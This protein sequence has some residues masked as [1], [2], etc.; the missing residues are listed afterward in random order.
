MFGGNHELQLARSG[1]MVEAIDPIDTGDVIC[2]TDAT[3]DNVLVSAVIIGVQNLEVVY[4]CIS[5][6]SNIE[7]KGSSEMTICN[8]G[9]I[10]SD[11]KVTAKLVLKANGERVNVRAYTKVL[12][13][14][15]CDDVITMEKLLRVQF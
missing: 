6:K 14:I 15:I 13:E 9:Q 7:Q 4:S 11:G 3:A 12:S 5:C 1:C 8:T 10:L 2:D